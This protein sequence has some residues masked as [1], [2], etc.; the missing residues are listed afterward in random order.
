MTS[1]VMIYKA[2]SHVTLSRM[3]KLSP[4]PALFPKINGGY[5]PNSPR[6][7]C[8]R[9]FRFTSHGQILEFTQNWRCSSHALEYVRSRSP[10]SKYFKIKFK[11]KK[12]KKREDY[13]PGWSGDKS[14]D[15]YSGDAWF[16]S[17]SGHCYS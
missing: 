17:R 2:M 12:K 13:R 14:L 3:R 5:F 4:A 10:I 1:Y 11:P 15:F 16:G 6:I 8:N 9:A 7:M